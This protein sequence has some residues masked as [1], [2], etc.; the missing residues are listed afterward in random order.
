MRPKRLDFMLFRVGVGIKR[1]FLVHSRRKRGGTCTAF[2]LQD[3][4]TNSLLYTN[5]I[6]NSRRRFWKSQQLNYEL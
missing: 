6:V 2:S 4:Q 3:K 1:G 5:T